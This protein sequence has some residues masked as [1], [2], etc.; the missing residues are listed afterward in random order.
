MWCDLLVS[1][2]CYDQTIQGL[3]VKEYQRKGCFWSAERLFDPKWILG[4]KLPGSYGHG[5][6]ATASKVVEA[7]NSISRKI[8]Q[9]VH[10]TLWGLIEEAISV[11]VKGYGEEEVQAGLSLEPATTPPQC[12]AAL[13][14]T[15]RRELYE[16]QQDEVIRQ[17][18][19]RLPLDDLPECRVLADALSGSKHSVLNEFADAVLTE[20]EEWTE[21]WMIPEPLAPLKDTDQE[22]IKEH[23]QKSKQSKSKSK[24][25]T[26]SE[27]L[28]QL[29]TS[30]EHKY[31]RLYLLLTD[32]VRLR[33]PNQPKVFVDWR[34]PTN[35]P[36]LGFSPAR[37]G[38]ATWDPTCM[39]FHAIDVKCNDGIN[40]SLRTDGPDPEK[41]HEDASSS[42][43]YS[44]RITIDE[45]IIYFK[46]VVSDRTEEERTR[47]QKIC[48][49]MMACTSRPPRLENL[50]P[51]IG[52][53]STIRDDDWWHVRRLLQM[54]AVE[55]H[56]TPQDHR[57]FEQKLMMLLAAIEGGSTEAVIWFI[58]LEGILT[59]I[60]QHAHQS[61]GKTDPRLQEEVC[62]E[63]VAFVHAVAFTSIALRHHWRRPHIGKPS[64]DAANVQKWYTVFWKARPLCSD[65]ECLRA[66]PH[67]RVLFQ[68][69][70]RELFSIGTCDGRSGLSKIR[71]FISTNRNTIYPCLSIWLRCRDPSPAL[72]LIFLS[73]CTVFHRDSSCKAVRGKFSDSF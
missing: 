1:A 37:F 33:I 52:W 39:L 48:R 5:S 7:V 40:N 34:V 6:V 11:A 45:A 12:I 54:L 29:L 49:K 21:P 50:P 31:A 62:R 19:S 64:T 70:S 43:S 30:Q 58:V 42:G 17:A 28:H 14:I 2:V 56:F 25:A 68:D 55:C 41:L 27:P 63:L 65:S 59:K 44:L 9:K 16:M 67:P 24:P 4:Q 57:N 71:S 15:A 66:L 20:L 13:L 38:V 61:H 46:R 60:A 26:K 22:M 18:I 73:Y 35:G 53:S 23:Q 32:R 3:M 72:I 51:K 47:Y 69:R 36:L 10:S 8:L